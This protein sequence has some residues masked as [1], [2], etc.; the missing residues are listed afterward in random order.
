MAEEHQPEKPW[1]EIAE[2]VSQER[3]SDKIF[4]LT[5]ALLQ[6]LDKEARQRAEK[7]NEIKQVKPRRQSA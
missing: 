5:E 3:D 7:M 4:E 2:E 1:R 6:A